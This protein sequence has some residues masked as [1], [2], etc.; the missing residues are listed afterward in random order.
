MCCAECD[1]SFA[2]ILINMIHFKSTYNLVVITCPSC[3]IWPW[4]KNHLTVSMNIPIGLQVWYSPQVVCHVLYF[5][6]GESSFTRIGI[7]TWVAARADS[8]YKELR[9]LF[10][11]I[12][13]NSFL[14][15]NVM[16]FSE[17]WTKIHD[18]HNRFYKKSTT[19]L[20]IS[21]KK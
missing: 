4:Y 8:C 3:C 15:F 2:T 20:H 6:L 18:L 10:I 1:V 12:S 17:R 14:T 16:L 7:L 11:L 13:F 9:N 5:Y 21:T 19:F